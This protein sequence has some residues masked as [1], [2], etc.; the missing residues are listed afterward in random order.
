MGEPGA[1][2]LL[3]YYL[4]KLV[5][6]ESQDR[7]PGLLEER[8]GGLELAQVGVE[9]IGGQLGQRVLGLV[10]RW[11]LLVRYRPTLACKL[12]S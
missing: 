4:S 11:R 2:F 9:L 5:S 10:D 7:G 3:G 6:H 12:D 1:V 8:D